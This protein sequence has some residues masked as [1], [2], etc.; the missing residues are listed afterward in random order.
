M[1]ETGV[2]ASLPLQRNL[3]FLS[4]IIFYYMVIEN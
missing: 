4:E 1:P 2:P 3:T